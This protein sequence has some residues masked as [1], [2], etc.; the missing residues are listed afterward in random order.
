MK[1]LKYLVLAVVVLLAGLAIYTAMQPSS[2]E[3]KRTQTIKAPID[4]VYNYVDDYK[5]W[6]AWGPWLEED[7]NLKMMYNEQTSGI[8][9][10]YSWE[11]KD[12]VG[13]ATRKA[14]VANE[15]I[16][17]ELDFDSMGKAITK[18]DLKTV[19]G[20]T[21]ATWTMSAEE[22][23]F[24]M[25][26]FSAI[27]GGY[28][29]MMGPMFERGLVK[30]D[31][32]SQIKAKE[33]AKTMNAYRLGEITKSPYEPQKFI[34]YP[35]SSKMDM[36]EMMGYFGTS[37]PKAGAYAA[38]KGLTLGEYTPGSVFTKWDDEKG[39]AEFMI[40]LFVNDD[41][42]PGEGMQAI[43]LAKGETVMVSKYGEYGV[44][45]DK[46]HEAIKAY[47]EEHQLTVSGPIYEMYTNDPAT[48]KPNE[49]QTNLYY[50]VN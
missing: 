34:G 19:D 42:S 20:G 12:G 39:E 8:G 5:N 14:A 2:Y 27:S 46:A 36:E 44:G 25:K 33:V 17:D 41:V 47:I 37:L 3:I 23:P 50:P 10:S 30:L 24:I 15:M 16:S 13:S 6:E 29:S 49:I 43:T 26:F 18:W 21:E 28:D 35:H 22:T 4:V 9:A 40:G 38:E 11:G 7:P 1:I 31:S 32:V 45:D 48:V